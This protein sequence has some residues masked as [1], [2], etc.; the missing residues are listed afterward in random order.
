MG[1]NLVA[2]P[3]C[4]LA[5]L[6]V[7]ALVVEVFGALLELVEHLEHILVDDL[8]SLDQGKQECFVGYESIVEPEFYQELRLRNDLDQKA[9]VLRYFI[10]LE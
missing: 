9:R 8:A 2:L 1:G 5:V 3:Q 7:D 6:A 10:V 4:I